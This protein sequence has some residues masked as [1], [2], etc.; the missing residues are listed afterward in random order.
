MLLHFYDASV[1]GIPY[2]K[3]IVKR[4]IGNPKSCRKL[5]DILSF[6]KMDVSGNITYNSSG[7]LLDNNLPIFREIYHAFRWHNDREY[8]SPMAKL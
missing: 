6:L 1:F 3:L 5:R 2:Y 8:F 7:I 4:C